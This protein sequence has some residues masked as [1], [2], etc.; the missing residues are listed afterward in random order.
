MQE[1]YRKHH[2]TI[3]YLFKL[4]LIF[5]ISIL[6]ARMWL[7]YIEDL[8]ACK[9]SKAKI[10]NELEKC[11]SHIDQLKSNF[12]KNIS[13]LEERLQLA[14]DNIHL[15][16]NEHNKSTLN[17]KRIRKLNDNLEQCKQEKEY[18][19]GNLT[20]KEVEV[21]MLSSNNS[22]CLNKLETCTG[23]LS[24]CKTDLEDQTQQYESCL[25][26]QA[27]EKNQKDQCAISLSNCQSQAEYVVGDYSTC[28]SELNKC[29]EDLETCKKRRCFGFNY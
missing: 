10:E 15:L 22:V 21:V 26:A 3:I 1:L 12:V 28:K 4:T 2:K 29:N 14:Q 6:F 7:G 17:E 23:H 9:E 13:T 25:K 19:R 27:R 8:R 20:A 5:I 11:K 16:E 18:L 24:T